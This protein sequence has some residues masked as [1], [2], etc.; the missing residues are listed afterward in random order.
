MYAYNTSISKTTCDTPFFLTYGCEPVK[1]SYVALL[2]RYQLIRSNSTDYH[3]EPLIRQIWT[4]RQLETECTQQ[5]QQC[6][7]LYYDQNVKDHPFRVGHKVWIYNPAVKLGL[8]K[9]LR[10]VWHSPLCL[11]DQI[12]P[13]LFSCQPSREIAERLSTCKSHETIL[14]IWWPSHRPSP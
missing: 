1:L 2:I 14:Y 4:A 11:I 3:R 7:K 9:K 13:V 5:A 10:C 6:M 12:T 8:S